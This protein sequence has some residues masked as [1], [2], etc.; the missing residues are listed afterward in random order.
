M[1][2]PT[3]AFPKL[4]SRSRAP[5]G[6]AHASLVFGTRKIDRGWRPSH[7]DLLD[8]I[9]P[10]RDLHQGLDRTRARPGFQLAGCAI[11][12]SLGLY[13]KPGPRRLDPDPVPLRRWRIL[14][15]INRPSRPAET[16]G[17]YSGAEDRRD[18]GL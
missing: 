2:R 17:R 1:V 5:D 3:T 9:G 11:R 8:Q 4:P 12:G 6:M 15:R 18:R 14:G 10:L 16:V 7:E 13:Q